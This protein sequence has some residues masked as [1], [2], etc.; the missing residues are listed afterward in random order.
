MVWLKVTISMVR[1]VK[2]VGVGEC[3]GGLLM[4]V[5]VGV[6]VSHQ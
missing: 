2:I 1:I 3:T 6:E 5:H 4:S